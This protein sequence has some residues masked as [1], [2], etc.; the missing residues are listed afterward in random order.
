VHEDAA[1]REAV[2]PT[3]CQPIGL[4]PAGGL[5]LRD[6]ADGR[7]RPVAELVWRVDIDRTNLSAA[8]K[9]LIGGL[10][11]EVLRELSLDAERGLMGLWQPPVRIGLAGSAAA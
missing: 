5:E 7:V 9:H 3:K 6:R 2:I 1:P 8:A 11:A 4:R 10:H